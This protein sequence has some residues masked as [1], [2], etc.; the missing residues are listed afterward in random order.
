MLACI[1][2]HSTFPEVSKSLYLITCTALCRRNPLISC[3][4]RW[5]VWATSEAHII[6]SEPLRLWHKDRFGVCAW[7]HASFPLLKNHSS[8]LKIWTSITLFI[9]VQLKFLRKHQNPSLKSFLF[10]FI[11]VMLTICAEQLKQLNKL[12][13]PATLYWHKS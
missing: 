3:R 11:L 13:I 2:N 6:R 9:H 4:G 12:S 10:F 8:Y 7:S 1:S 5:C